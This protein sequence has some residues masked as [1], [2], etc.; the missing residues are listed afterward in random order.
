M[1]NIARDSVHQYGA[2]LASDFY[3]Q[4]HELED[5]WISLH[6]HIFQKSNDASEE[7]I[8]EVEKCRLRLWIQILRD[9]HGV[10][11]IDRWVS[12]VNYLTSKNG[13]NHLDSLM[14]QAR[15]AYICSNVQMISVMIVCLDILY[16]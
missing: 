3:L 2:I 10:A 16:S 13:L 7:T 5:A 1:L 9:D 14:V 4:I 6:M 11:K 15:Y 12:D 8:L